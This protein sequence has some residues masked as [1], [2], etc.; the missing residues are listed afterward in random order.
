[1]GLSYY[2]HWCDRLLIL[3]IESL[4][5]QIIQSLRIVYKWNFYCIGING[6]PLPG[7]FSYS[8]QI[9]FRLLLLPSLDLSPYIYNISITHFNYNMSNGNSTKNTFPFFVW[10]TSIIRRS[11]APA[12]LK[13][14]AR[15]PLIGDC[16]AISVHK[17]LP[18]FFSRSSVYWD[19]THR[20]HRPDVCL[21]VFLAIP[22]SFLSY[23]LLHRSQCLACWSMLNLRKSPP[24]TARRLNRR[25]QKKQKAKL[26]GKFWKFKYMMERRTILPRGMQWCALRQDELDGGG[27][28]PA[29]FEK[30]D[31]RDGAILSI[32]LNSSN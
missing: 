8:D 15:L 11:N 9:D 7:S 22:T 23:P 19:R 20:W 12:C 31:A 1:M 4:G 25:Q 27:K 10:V 16:L 18:M 28:K 32:Y 14:L 30:K 24:D 21:C 26:S 13:S 29:S 3:F 17:P 5:I 6:I 2:S